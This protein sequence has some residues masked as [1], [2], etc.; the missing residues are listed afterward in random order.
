[1]GVLVFAAFRLCYREEEAGS[2]SR[3]TLGPYFPAM[4]FYDAFDYSQTQ[5]GATLIFCSEA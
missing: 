3:H 4:G 5:S 2:L 1:M